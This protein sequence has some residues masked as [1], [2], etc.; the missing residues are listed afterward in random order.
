MALE[1]LR[2]FVAVCRAGS[3]SAVARELDC[4][5]SAVSQHVRRL[6]REAGVSL[7]ERQPRGV[8]PTHVHAAADLFRVI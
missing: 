4:T 5:Q 2:V 6:A 8:V 7:L 3:L 1:D